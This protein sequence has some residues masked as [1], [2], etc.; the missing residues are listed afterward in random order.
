MRRTTAP[1]APTST[2]S[3]STTPARP[4]QRSPQAGTGCN[5][6]DAGY[7]HSC[8]WTSIAGWPSSS[9]IYTQGDQT[10]FAAGLANVP[11]GRYLISVLADGYKLDGRHFTVAAV[12]L[13]GTASTRRIRQASSGCC[14]RRCP[15]AQIQAAVFEDIS[16]V[17]S[18]PDLP[19]EHGLAGFQGHITDYLGEVTTDV[20]GAPLCSGTTQ[21]AS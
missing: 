21:Q 3:T 14:S 16:P 12:S 19:A 17:N 5:P 13:P 11:D 7:P 18:A 1:L 4:T 6:Q 20:Y 9:P 10:D 2:S 15:T 8:L